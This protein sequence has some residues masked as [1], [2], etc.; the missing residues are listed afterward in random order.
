MIRVLLDS[1]NPGVF[2]AGAQMV[3]TYSD[4]ATPALRDRLNA[5]HDTVIWID[6]GRGDPLHLATVIDVED[7]LHAPGDAPGWY[8]RRRQAGAHNLTVYCTRN[9][10]PGVNAA[11]GN[12]SF[13]RWIATLDGTLHI[14]G[15]SPLCAPARSSLPARN[16]P[17]SML[18][19][20]WCTTTTGMPTADDALTGGGWADLQRWTLQKVGGW[21]P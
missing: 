13:F 21:P 1:D 14:K 10:L 3:A 15:F 19:F 18:T 4:L 17:A 12:R 7:H 8:D 9:G 11:M 2:P 6:R 16:M 20:R 5:A